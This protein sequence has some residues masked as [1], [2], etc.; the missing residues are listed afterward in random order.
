MTR[1]G[2]DLAETLLKKVQRSESLEVID[3]ATGGIIQQRF[4]KL[5]SSPTHSKQAATIT[6]ITEWSPHEDPHSWVTE[7]LEH[8]DEESMTLVLAGISKDGQGSIGLREYNR[9]YQQEFQSVY[10]KPE[11]IDRMRSEM[12]EVALKCWCDWLDISTN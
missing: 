11:L 6:L 10:R 7:I 5:L 4:S 12:A 8:A 9:I 2:E 3:S 1:Q